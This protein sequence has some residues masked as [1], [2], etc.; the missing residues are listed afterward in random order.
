MSATWHTTD[1]LPAD[2]MAEEIEA[3]YAEGLGKIS[4]RLREMEASF[5]SQMCAS[6]ALVKMIQDAPNPIGAAEDPTG[7]GRSVLDWN[8]RVVPMINK[9][10]EATTNKPLPKDLLVI[11]APLTDLQKR[12]SMQIRKDKAAEAS[13]TMARINIARFLA[14]AQKKYAECIDRLRKLHETFARQVQDIDRI[15][16]SDKK[17]ASVF[18]AQARK[19]RADLDRLAEELSED[20]NA[21]NTNEYFTELMKMTMSAIDKDKTAL[22]IRELA[23]DP[24]KRT[25]ELARDYKEEI[26]KILSD[27][28]KIFEAKLGLAVDLYESEKKI[29]EEIKMYYRLFSSTLQDADNE[30]LRDIARRWGIDAINTIVIIDSVTRSRRERKDDN[31]DT[32][33]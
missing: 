26:K 25:A 22:A 29:E 10:A 14:D 21:N 5:G 31:E 11:E 33:A 30:N 19:I 17:R 4:E 1:L 15:I 23:S 6:V 28:I 20:V 18:E 16:A 32:D 8:T 9:L 12:R 7:S 27:C 2:A 3:Y 24:N 13:N